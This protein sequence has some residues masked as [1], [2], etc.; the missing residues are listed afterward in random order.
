MGAEARILDAELPAPVG[1]PAATLS[2]EEAE[3]CRA[4]L[5]QGSKSFHAASLLLPRRMRLPAAAVYAFC[6]VAD[7]A[8]DDAG[9]G[10]AD[11]GARQAAMRQ[12]LQ[13]LHDRLDRIY[14]ADPGQDPVD[15][16]FAAVARAH[17]IPRE[18]PL[19]LLEGFAWDAL[20]RRYETLSDVRAYGVRV[21]SSVGLMMTCLM[22]PDGDRWPLGLVY[23]RAC[24]LGVAMQLTNI[25]RDVG[26]DARMGRVYLPADLLAEVGLAPEALVAE[27]RFRPELGEVVRRL[28]DEADRLYARADAGIAMLP[29]DCRV[30]IRAARLIYAAIGDRVARRGYDSVSGRA[31]TSAGRKLWLA[32]RALSALLPTRPPPSL[33]LAP[34]LPEAEPLVRALVGGAAPGDEAP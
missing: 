14:S 2:A 11:P 24:D 34:V 32:L 27:P 3:T 25:A 8:V 20:G 4:L 30:A 26:E 29:W 31:V 17:G 10:I 16:A 18:L 23:A 1:G 5:A 7:D 13:G 12:A 21:A 9:L 19:A 22:R 28:L 6:R 33:A 15:R